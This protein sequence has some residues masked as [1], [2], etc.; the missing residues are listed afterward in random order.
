[1][2]NKNEGNGAPKYTQLAKT[3]L[4]KLSSYFSVN[5]FYSKREEKSETKQ[6]NTT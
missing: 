6:Q 5:K 1:M 4:N 3:I 2:P